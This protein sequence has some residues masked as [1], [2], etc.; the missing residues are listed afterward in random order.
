MTKVIVSVE[1]RYLEYKG[2]IYVKGIEDQSFFLRYLERFSVVYILARVEKTLEK[3]V[4]YSVFEH[5][6]ILFLPIYTKGVGFSKFFKIKEYLSSI[7]HPVRILLRTPGLVAYISF[8]ACF[9]FKIPYSIEVVA[10]PI[11]EASS[12]YKSK[13]LSCILKKLF[14]YIFKHQIRLARFASFVTKFELQ[15]ALLKNQLLNSERYNS[16]YSS[17]DLNSSF[18][19]TQE[20]LFL[21]FNN[22]NLKEN[23]TLLFVGVLEKPFKGL[24]VFIDIISSLPDK[25]NGIVVGDGALLEYYKSYAKNAGIM[26]RI[27]FLGYISDLNEK[28]SIY[29]LADY[30]VLC[31][32]R[33]GLP[34]VL[35]EA[36]AN[37]LPCIST[38]V[39]GA[40]ELIDEKYIY[41]IDDHHMAIN[42]IESITEVEYV[43]ASLINYKNSKLY[44]SDNI[45]SRRN[46]FYDKVISDAYPSFK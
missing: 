9:L 14:S 13:L 1:R 43:N 21:K 7:E 38:S 30:F 17:I 6:N 40:R 46:E 34:R 18:Y 26:H 25:Y 36:M 29:S 16:H 20:Q 42:I 5:P 45:S 22:L 27:K 15:K 31:S 32:R 3:P 10:N 35:I 44:S 28:K 33:E 11:Q 2:F 24:D 4:G 12:V 19:I 8:I 37:G 39:S 41:D 23:V